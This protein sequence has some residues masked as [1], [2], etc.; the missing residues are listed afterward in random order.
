MC[1]HARLEGAHFPLALRQ[2]FGLTETGFLSLEGIQASVQG[3]A[4]AFAT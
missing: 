4:K 1:L 3:Q 2:R